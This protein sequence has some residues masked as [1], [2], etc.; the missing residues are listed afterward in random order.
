MSWPHL[1]S[2]SRIVVSPFIAALA[3]AHA[4]DVYLVAALLFA[5]A[6]LT[7]AFDGKL[8]R[9]SER[10]SPLGIFLDTTA[11]KVLVGL[12]LVALAVAGLAPVWIVL[13][14]IGREFLISGLRSFAASYDEIISA[15]AWGKGKAAITMIAITLVLSSAAGQTGGVL[16]HVASHSQWHALYLVSQGTLVLAAVLTIVSGVRYFVDAVPLFRRRI[17]IHEVPREEQ[18]RV[19]ASGDGR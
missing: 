4:G 9:R 7:D 18:R 16:G 8:A 14:I 10:V 13:V 12:S 17:A 15:H 3:L 5:L 1:L 6:S 11:D 19:A 2:F